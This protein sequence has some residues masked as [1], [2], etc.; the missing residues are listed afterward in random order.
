MSALPSATLSAQLRS[1]IKRTIYGAMIFP[2]AIC[3][4]VRFQ[5]SISGLPSANAL[6]IP[7][8]NGSDLHGS[9]RLALIR[10][11]RGPLGVRMLS[12]VC[13]TIHGLE[14]LGGLS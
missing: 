6:P 4:K 8:A 7:H 10:Q 5:S 12:F 1:T 3:R 11:N 9:L 13:L 14:F 2:T